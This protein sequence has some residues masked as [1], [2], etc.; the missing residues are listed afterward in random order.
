M[1]ERIADALAIACQ[2]AQ[3]PGENHRLWVID[4]MVRALTGTEYPHWVLVAT[5]DAN[6]NEGAF[7]WQTGTPP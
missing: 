2:Y 1:S 3:M 4:Q 5:M 7:V 6:G